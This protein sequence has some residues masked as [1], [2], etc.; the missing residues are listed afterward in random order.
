MR[1]LAEK[2]LS[3]KLRGLFTSAERNTL[4]LFLKNY[5]DPDVIAYQAYEIL[6]PWFDIET[7]YNQ[8]I[9]YETTKAM[10]NG[11]KSTID[12]IN[13]QR[14][15]SKVLRLVDFSPEIYSNLQRQTFI[16]SQHTLNRVK[17]NIMTILSDGYRDGLGIKEV[18]RNLIKEFSKLKGYEAQRIA[19]TEINSAQNMGNYQTLQDFDVNY[20]Q[21]WTGQDARVRDSHK[22]IHGQITRVGNAFSNGLLYPGDRTGPIKEWINC[23]CTGVPYLMPLGFMAPPG[24]VTFKESDIIP[25]PGFEVPETLFGKPPKNLI[26]P[27][28]ASKPKTTKLKQTKPTPKTKLDPELNKLQKK[29]VL[30]YQRD[31]FYNLNSHLRHR[32]MKTM[33][34]QE[35]LMVKRLDSAM[36]PLKEAT[37]VQRS[38]G[39]SVGSES[40]FGEKLLK[41]GEGGTITDKGYVSTT[42]GK[43]TKLTSQGDR[44]LNYGDKRYKPTNWMAEIN[45][46]K[47]SKSIDVNKVLGDMSAFPGEK[48]LLLHRGSKFRIEEIL[49]ESKWVK[50]TLIN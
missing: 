15:Q 47:G 38:I 6:T 37:T 29:T 19:R 33:R 36:T 50:L 25:I 48:E 39:R 43:Q 27:V 4:R 21:W 11:R 5:G 42:L 3:N 2:A 8:T 28:S 17:N 22:E 46:P 32:T 49:P 30:D 26:K 40:K 7:Q 14:E 44:P 45:I 18:E 20:Q 10:R 9:L 34:K 12:L 13:L 1:L 23:R 16:A 35:K 41:A 31:K 24:M